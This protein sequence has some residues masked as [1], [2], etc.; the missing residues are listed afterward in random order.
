MSCVYRNI[1]LESDEFYQICLHLLSCIQVPLHILGTFIILKKTPKTMGRVKGSMLTLHLLTAWL[2]ILLTVFLVPV[3]FFAVFAGYPLG[4]F[5]YL[6]VPTKAM[7]YSVYFPI[8]FLMVS[9]VCF[10]EN[11][12]NY[13]V[14]HDSD[15]PS[16]KKKRSILYFFNYFQTLIC[17]TI[18]F[19]GG[20]ANDPRLIAHQTLPCL[21]PEVLE[22]PNFFTLEVGGRGANDSRL[23]VH[24]KL[25]CLPQKILENPNFFMLEVDLRYLISSAG[26]YGGVVCGQIVYYFSATSYYLFRT[27][28]QSSRT[29]QLQKKFFKTLCV[30]ITIPICCFMVPGA[31]FVYTYFWE[32]LDMPLN[33]LGMIAASSHGLVSTLIML[34]AHKPYREATLE[35]FGMRMNARTVSIVVAKPSISNVK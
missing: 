34:L 28:A 12:Y 25:P 14:R 31:Y 24:Q 16:R 18:L 33:I 29:S 10:F 35:C 5:V 26:F 17:V 7:I 20:G 9:I 30:Q 32:S 8:F 22:N 13:L 1:Y 2:D 11:R 15:T 4:L 19:S 23:I 21:T 6:G 3:V 27:K